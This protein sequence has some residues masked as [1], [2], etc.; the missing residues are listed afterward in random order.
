MKN[1]TKTIKT[2]LVVLCAGLFTCGLFA[3]HVQAVPI[4][5]QIS[6]SG[7]VALNTNSLLTATAVSTWRDSANLNL[8]FCNAFGVD[9]SFTGIVGLAAMS[10]WTFG[11][12]VGGA[13]PALWSIDGFT[14]DL[15]GSNV[16]MRNATD[17]VISGTGTIHGGPGFDDTAGSWDFHVSNAGGGTHANFSFAASTASVPDGGSTVALLGIALTG[18][19]ALRRRFAAR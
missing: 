9:G 13:Q 8:G 17:L 3:P 7:R 11:V 6:F 14:F 12:A 15:L 16:T 18:L 5:G 1:I 10:P 4:T 2:T 19:E